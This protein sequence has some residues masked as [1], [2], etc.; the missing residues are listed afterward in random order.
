MELILLSII[1]FGIFVLIVFKVYDN[2]NKSTHT[3]PIQ[4]EQSNSTDLINTEQSLI[5][6]PI[7][8]LSF[9]EALDIQTFDNSLVEK[10]LVTLNENFL[11]E[12][13]TKNL[14]YLDNISSSVKKIKDGV[15]W[16]ISDK[17][18]KLIKTGKA[19][20]I[21]HKK[22]GNL[23]P[24]IQDAKTNKFIEQFKGRPLN[25]G[26]KLAKLSNVLVN[27]AHIISGA[28]VSKKIKLLDKKVEYLIAGRKIDQLSKIEANYN[29]A[30]ELLFYSLN[31]ND[32]STLK[33]LHK[34]NLELRSVWRR[35]MELKLDKIEDPN[36]ISWIKKR[37]SR[38]KTR[39]KKAKQSII[40]CEFEKEIRL[41]DFTISFDLALCHAIGNSNA[42]INTSLSDE[43]KRLNEIGKILNKKKSYIKIISEND[44]VE[45][46]IKYLDY[47]NEK[48]S[49]FVPV[50]DSQDMIEDNLYDE[51]IELLE[52]GDGE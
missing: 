17:G 12:F 19:K 30:R 4:T 18:K 34:D 2:S 43:I 36:N 40:E 31:G 16:E 52:Q 33:L 21:L 47:V 22:T 46:V 49:S 39:D 35:E 15:V 23:L 3:Y 28:D 38:Q 41:I 42:F 25:M 51:N 9:E 13:G 27:C 37:F 45:S 5:N 6:S 11:K 48:Y 29:L 8:D 7:T 10:A 26:S 50:D 44:D 1:L 14:T 20:F 24:V 32:I